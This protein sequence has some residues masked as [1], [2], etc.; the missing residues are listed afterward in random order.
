[1]CCVCTF[2]V[3]LLGYKARWTAQEENSTLEFKGQSVANKLFIFIALLKLSGEV[4]GG[5][6]LPH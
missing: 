4:V 5:N 3:H 1:M 6:Y 2:S